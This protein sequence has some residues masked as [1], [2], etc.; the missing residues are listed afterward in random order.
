MAEFPALPLWTDAL[1]GD[2]YHLT[3]AEFG[4]YMRLLIV[5][6]RRKDCDLPADDVFLG[7][8]I[9]DP[10]NWHRLRATVMAYFTLGTD[11]LYRQKRLLDERDYVSRCAAKS[12][13]GGRAKALKRRN[14]GSAYDLPNACLTPAPTP[15][16][17]PIE[18][19]R[20]RV[21]ARKPIDKAETDAF[22]EFYENYPRREGRRTA[23]KAFATAAKRAPVETI[24]AGS[25]RYALATTGTERRFVKLPAT[26]LN[27]DHW[28]DEIPPNGAQNGRTHSSTKHANA[29]K[30]SFGQVI[31]RAAMARIEEGLPGYTVLRPGGDAAGQ[32]TDDDRSSAFDLK[33]A[34]DKG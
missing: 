27:G 13:A 32:I 26:W 28:N 15:T 12:S 29:S 24:L 33:P 11:G 18:E 10:K 8:A 3:P 31:S 17:T 9:G 4:A 5:S 16:P 20:T 6:W 7:R 2:T 1:I 34:P 19:E 21:G 25:A 30:P 14:R 22:Q 23:A